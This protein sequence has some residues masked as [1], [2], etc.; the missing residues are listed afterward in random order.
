[1]ANARAP[2]TLSAGSARL[3]GEPSASAAPRRLPNSGYRPFWSVRRELPG[4]GARWGLFVTSRLPACLP[5]ILT[6]QPV[7]GAVAGRVWPAGQAQPGILDE[8][9]DPRRLGR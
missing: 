3:I 7:P 6:R 4:N 1:M 8:A 2:S 5:G 9:T